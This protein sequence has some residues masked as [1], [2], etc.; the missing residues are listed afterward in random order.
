MKQSRLYLLHAFT[1]VF[2]LIW[3]GGCGC[4]KQGGGIETVLIPYDHGDTSNQKI[5]TK[6]AGKP[7]NLDFS[8]TPANLSTSKIVID[9]GWLG[10][11]TI[12]F[13]NN[14][15]TNGSINYYV[16]SNTNPKGVLSAVTYNSTPNQISFSNI[17]GSSATQIFQNKT[18]TINQADK[19]LQIALYANITTG[20]DAQGKNWSGNCRGKYVV[21]SK[22]CAPGSSCVSQICDKDHRTN[23][24]TTS[25]TGDH[26]ATRPNRFAIIKN[27]GGNI[28]S[29]TSAAPL[30]LTFTAEDVGGIATDLYTSNTNLNIATIYYEDNDTKDSSGRMVGT[31]T[32]V[33]QPNFTNA[34]AT[35]AITQ[36]DDVGKV[37]LHFEDRN[38][39]AID[40][41][42]G[43][44]QNCSTTGGYLC[45]DLNATFIPASF[46]FD[47]ITVK[48]ANNGTFTYLS[49]DINNSSSMFAAMDITLSARN[50]LGGVTKNYASG[51]WEKNM[52]ITITNSTPNTP[53]LLTKD[54]NSSVKLGFNNGS[55]T[56][57][58]NESNNSKQLR[59]NFTRTT[60]IQLNPLKVNIG[61]LAL[62]ASA[63]YPT[64]AVTGNATATNTA[65]FLYARSH[66]PRQRFNTSNATDLIYFETYCYGTDANGNTCDKT[67]LPNSIASK[68]TDDPRWFVNTLHTPA[69]GKIIGTPSQIGV[70]TSKSTIGTI[71][72]TPA[73]ITKVPITYT[74]TKYPYKA[75][76]E[77]NA[78][79]WLLYDRYSSTSSPATANR[80]E[81]EFVNS[82]SSWAGSGENSASTA[83]SGASKTNRRTMW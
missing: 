12:N 58:W 26:F 40:N 20:C 56:I 83:S 6:V 1:T 72:T 78:S 22:G 48:N 55:K 57:A 64:G 30:D 14:V 11:F 28:N 19:D 13:G 39:A 35:N 67:L 44:P 8:L 45:G 52:K 9:L 46:T 31:S 82:A 36:F 79:S 10:S 3:S 76:F 63:T 69:T 50:A 60:N 43:T 49:N 53:T 32:I 51:L 25:V 33:T 27:G 17:T 24:Y 15:I 38:W 34:L 75:T 61:E 18:I 77:Y 21:T 42:D 73:G 65:T 47:T 66:A 29:V 23:C 7:F 59:F 81:V 70:A 80:F 74:G 62:N 37:T 68:Y 41:G 5:H 16:Y 4:S 71:T 2:I 54:I